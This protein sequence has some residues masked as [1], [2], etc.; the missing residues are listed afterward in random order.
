MKISQ[1]GIELIKSFEGCRL[2]AYDD[3]FGV[4]TIG[5]GH[6]SGV[7]KGQRISQ[8]LADYYLQQDISVFENAVNNNVTVY[9]T[10]NRFDALVSFT[11]NCGI[12]ALKGSTLLKKLNS[13]DYTGAS[14]EFLK[15]CK[16][17][18]G[19]TIQ[20][21][22]N[23]R[24]AEQKLFNTNTTI[25]VS[26]TIWGLQTILNNLGY[27]DKNGSRLIVDGIIGDLTLSACPI[28]KYGCKSDVVKWVQQKLSINADGI[29]GTQTKTS[30]INYQKERKLQHDGI[31]G[32]NTWKELT[33]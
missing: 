24:I 23:R 28:L 11:Y 8:A 13:G 7:K 20:G 29:F 2:K 9:L 4:W 26:N 30:V 17:S 3:G 19:N 16:D 22:Y 10:Q 31:V 5:Y 15:W 12:G 18:Q 1:K 14:N 27:R 25:S 6:T 33:R 32:R 21:L